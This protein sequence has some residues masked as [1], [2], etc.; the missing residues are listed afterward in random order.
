[1]KKKESRLI[2]LIIALLFVFSV[3]H[4]LFFLAKHNETQKKRE[5]QLLLSIENKIKNFGPS[6]IED[7]PFRIYI[8]V[9]SGEKTVFSYP[10]NATAPS[11]FLKRE[12]DYEF[13]AVY[14]GEIFDVYVRIFPVMDKE[15]FEH[16]LISFLLIFL[17]TIYSLFLIVNPG[18]KLKKFH[19]VKFKKQTAKKI[20]FDETEKF[21]ETQKTD[22]NKDS[23][24][25]ALAI[26]IDKAKKDEKNISLLLVEF[27]GKEGEEVRFFNKLN[28]IFEG[29]SQTFKMEEKLFAVIFHGE[30][31]E[32]AEEKALKLVEAAHEAM[33]ECFIGISSKAK[34]NVISKERLNYEAEEALKKAKKDVSEPIVSFRVD[35]K[36]YENFLK[37]KRLN[38]LLP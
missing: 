32:D 8:L 15:F 24:F 19:F 25:D 2:A 13:K 9:R 11:S 6:S 5:E 38:N 37:A 3:L 26:E 35:E 22:E 12:H 29:A 31:E 7:F 34:R 20:F 30:T 23:F 36:K 27:H 1:M 18:L 33:A 16:F 10:E 28:E 14:K 17:G 4:L 21:T